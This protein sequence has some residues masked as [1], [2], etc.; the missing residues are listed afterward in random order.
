MQVISSTSPI[1]CRRKDGA[2]GQGQ[3]AGRPAL[4]VTQNRRGIPSSSPSLLRPTCWGRPA[5]AATRSL[6]A[7][8]FSDASLILSLYFSQRDV[9]LTHSPHPDRVRESKCLCP[10]PIGQYTITEVRRALCD[11]L[12]LEPLDPVCGTPCDAS[13]D[14]EIHHGR[15]GRWRIFYF[16]Q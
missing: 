16:R 12:V 5:A 13:L 7:R 9:S 11:L 10:Y 6:G 1:F 4:G 2:A 8:S 14:A 15:H 3:R